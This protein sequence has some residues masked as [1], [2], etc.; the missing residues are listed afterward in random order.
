[1]TC[2]IHE[3]VRAHVGFLRFA[4]LHM[5]LQLA[6]KLPYASCNILLI[7]SGTVSLIYSDSVSFSKAI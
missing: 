7:R 5:L 3:K 6:S 4:F 1:M 2:A